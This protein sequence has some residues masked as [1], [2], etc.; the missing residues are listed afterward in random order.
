MPRPERISGEVCH[1]RP[2]YLG[3]SCDR[4]CGSLPLLVWK[5]LS[6][7]FRLRPAAKGPIFYELPVPGINSL[8]EFARPILFRSAHRIEFVQLAACACMAW[9]A[10]RLQRLP[11]LLGLAGAL[12]MEWNAA[13]YRGQ[14]LD[15]DLPLAVLLILAAWPGRWREILADDAVPTP[16]SN[17]VGRCLL[18][19]VGMVYFLCGLSKPLVAV[20]WPAVAQLHMSRTVMM[21]NISAEFP[22]GLDRIIRALETLF[23][24]HPRFDQAAALLSTLLEMG[25]IAGLFHDRCRRVLP[26]LAVG[27]HVGIVLTMG[28]LFLP[29]CLTALIVAQPWRGSTL[30]P[31]L[32][33]EPTRWFNGR[34]AAALVVAALLAAGP[35]V[36]NASWPPF[37]NYNLFGFRFAEYPT[38][39][40]R[41]GFE[42]RHGPLAA[43]RTIIAAF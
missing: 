14:L 17:L 4:F 11:L 43:C 38:T 37:D 34:V 5:L 33:V 30:T 32:S 3:K 42:T 8:L 21:C 20:N 15:V 7:D 28:V 2:D 6:T 27:M 9:G 12:V 35:A 41:L 24:H 36:F 1:V 13:Q 23:R 19:Y 31:T 10:I 18:G 29:F 16:A 39:A 25:W 26:W 40:Y 22:C